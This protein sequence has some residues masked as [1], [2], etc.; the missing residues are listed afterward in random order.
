MSESVRSATGPTSPPRPDRQ[1]RRTRGALTRIAAAAAAAV[2]L[3]PLAAASAAAHVRA[4]PESTAAGGYTTVTF[5]VPTES[6]TASTTKISIALPTDTPLVHVSVRPVSGWTAAV[7]QGTLP[8]PVTVGGTTITTAPT[9]VT[10]TARDGGGVGPGEFEEF[11]ISGGP[12]PAEGTTLV[13]PAAQTYSD[14]TV[15]DWDEVSAD[16][17]EPDH[18]APAFTVTASDGSAPGHGSASTASGSDADHGAAALWLAA[19]ALVLAVAALVVALVPRRRHGDL[20]T[21]T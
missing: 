18:P 7:Q 3:V 21:T 20:P 6:D 13:F 11:E 19:A 16:G 14:G 1:A 9:S 2:V 10:W 17:A 5:R 4:V 15:V 12:L 8:S